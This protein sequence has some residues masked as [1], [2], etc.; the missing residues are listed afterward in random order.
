[1]GTLSGTLVWG[2]SGKGLECWTKDRALSCGWWVTTEGFR[3]L[4]LAVV[5]REE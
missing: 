1:M 2:Q 5:C 4:H 3:R